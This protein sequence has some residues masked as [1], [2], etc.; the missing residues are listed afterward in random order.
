MSSER[1]MTDQNQHVLQYIASILIE[2]KDTING[3]REDMRERGRER[4]RFYKQWRVGMSKLDLDNANV[5]EE[6]LTVNEIRDEDPEKMDALTI[7]LHEWLDNA[8][9]PVFTGEEKVTYLVIEI[10]K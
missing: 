8:Q 3:I 7:K 4:R 2:I 6:I 9:G 1:A 5:F 10:T